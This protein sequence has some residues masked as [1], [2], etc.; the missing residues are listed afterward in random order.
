MILASHKLPVHHSQ[1]QLA[2]TIP[3]A[4][5]NSRISKEY[6]QK[7]Y[8]ADDHQKYEDRMHDVCA[9]AQASGHHAEQAFFDAGSSVKKCTLLNPLVAT[10]A[11]DLA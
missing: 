10:A 7:C 8:E 3:N 2:H 1:P 4:W 9:S 5:Q 6:D 11:Q